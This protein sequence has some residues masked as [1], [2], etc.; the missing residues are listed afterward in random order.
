LVRHSCIVIDRTSG[1]EK[2][3]DADQ[4]GAYEELDGRVVRITPN[5]PATGNAQNV[6]RT[7]PSLGKLVI[8]DGRAG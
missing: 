2:L 3:S 7:K 1:G 5:R 8:G 6:A 4:G